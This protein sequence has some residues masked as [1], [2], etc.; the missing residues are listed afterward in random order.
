MDNAD[1]DLKGVFLKLTSPQ[2]LTEVIAIVLAG[3]I[4]LAGAQVV[5]AWHRKYL[6][7]SGASRQDIWQLRVLEGAALLAPFLVA[8]IVLLVIRWALTLLG[9]ATNAVDTALQLTTALVLVRLGVY[10]LRVMMGPES[11]L[12]TWENRITL[13]LWVTIGFSMVGWLDKVEST[14]NRINLI[15]G[16]TQFSLWALLKGLVIV[17]A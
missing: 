3:L 16:K 10:L 15:P 2:I 13:V 9:N 1:N 14:L 7:T 8:L 12:R 4:A 5:R 11:W 17:T 6:A